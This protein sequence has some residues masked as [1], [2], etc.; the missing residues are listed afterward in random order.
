[1]TS[2]VAQMVWNL[3]AVQETWVSTWV[4]KIPWRREW[5]PTPVFLPGK[6][7]WTEESGG[8]QTMGSQRVGHDWATNT[9]PPYP[10]HSGWSRS[11]IPLTY[12]CHGW[13]AGFCVSVLRCLSGV[14]QPSCLPPIFSWTAALSYPSGYFSL[15]PFFTINIFASSFSFLFLP[16]LCLIF[17]T[18]LIHP[19]S[20]C[21]LWCFFC[22]L[23]ISMCFPAHRLAQQS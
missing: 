7:P 17:P 2:L 14:Q 16:P 12:E 3:P 21:P 9:L 10:P 23:S 18:L 19:D 5:Q 20:P 11:C 4:K 15:T 1:M 6:F 22:P 8:I 13:L